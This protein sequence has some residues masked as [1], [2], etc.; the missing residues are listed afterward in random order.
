MRGN[1]VLIQDLSELAVV[2]LHA[3]P[4]VNDHVL[5]LQ[6]GQRALVLH[7]ILVRGEEHVEAATLERVG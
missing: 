1:V 2:V 6:L 4:L 3:V 5:P 7:D